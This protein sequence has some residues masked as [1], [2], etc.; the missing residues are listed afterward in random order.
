LVPPKGRGCAPRVHA[1]KSRKRGKDAV[2]KIAE[3]Q[4]DNS[5]KG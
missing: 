5:K 4:T 1:R 3:R 2:I